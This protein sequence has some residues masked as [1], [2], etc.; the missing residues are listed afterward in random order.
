MSKLLD[1][2]FEIFVI[3]LTIKYANAAKRL[4][5][6]PSRASGLGPGPR[7]SSYNFFVFCL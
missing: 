3:F 1:F 2:L 5:P 7:Y 6:D 4:A